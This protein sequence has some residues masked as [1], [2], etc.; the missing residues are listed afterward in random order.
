MTNQKTAGIGHNFPPNLID[1]ITAPFDDERQEAENWADGQDVEN[2]A[3]M[4]SVD[5]LRGKMR[6]WRL[7]LEAG[8]EEAVKPLRD[9]TNAE[10]DRWKPTIADAKRIEG[11]LVAAVGTFKAKLAE[12]KEAV[13]RAAWQAAQDAERAAEELAR[14]ADVSNLDAQREADAA[15]NAA[16]N[17]KKAAS[18]AQKDTVKGLRDVTHYEVTDFSDLLRWMNKH[19]R[20]ELEAAAAE[21]VR[22]NHKDGTSRPGVRVWKT[23]ESF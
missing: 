14:A 8:Q 23:K 19:A 10:R 11:C 16:L 4:A 21:Y 2:E 12:Q 13:R 17:A 6:Q 1:L 15:R 9:E 22:K 7:A 5:E 20:P 3:Q 18:A